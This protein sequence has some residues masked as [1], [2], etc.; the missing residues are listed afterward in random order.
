MSTESP[1][2]LPRG[3]LSHSAMD[4]WAKSKDRYRRKYY[5]DQLP[6]PTTP[7]MAFG[8]EIASLME[9]KKAVKKHPILRR[10]PRYSHSEYPLDVVIDGVP[11]KGFI[12]SFDPKKN[13]ILEYKTGIRDAKGNAPWDAVK[14]RRHDQLLLYSLCVEELLGE[15]H[16]VTKLV[17]V[18]TQWEERCETYQFGDAEITEC[19]PHLSLTGDLEVF[20]RPIDA[21]EREWM[22]K[23][24][25]RVATEISEDYKNYLQHG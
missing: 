14:V 23:E 5:G 16:P 15:V 8:K 13:R 1:F 12:D 17:W 7:Y 4:L 10:V 18:E 2:V 20:K 6:E 9:D 22:R 21:W 24:I 3:Y 19:G 25:V 11:I